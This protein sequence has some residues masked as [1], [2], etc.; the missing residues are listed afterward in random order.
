MAADDTKAADTKAANDTNI[1]AVIFGGKLR[2]NEKTIEKQL[3]KRKFN[4]KV[5][6]LVYDVLALA[7]SRVQ[8]V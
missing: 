5:L 8:I 3:H 2:G 6:Q 4:Y 1:I 7:T